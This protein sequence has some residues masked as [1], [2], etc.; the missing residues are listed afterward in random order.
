MKTESRKFTPKRD[1]PDETKA[2]KKHTGGNMAG[3]VIIGLGSTGKNICESVADKLNII[4]GSYKN[5]PN[6]G[7]KVFETAKNEKTLIAQEDY[8]HLSISQDDF[9][10]YKKNPQAGYEFDWGKWGNTSLISQLTGSGGVSAGAGGI[11]MV[12]RLALLHNYDSVSAKITKEIR[13]VDDKKSPTNVYVVGSLCGGTCSGIC[14]DFGYFIKE[15]AENAKIM[16]IFTIPLWSLKDEELK[17]NAFYAL[18]ELNHYMSKDNKWSQKVPKL[19]FSN[20]DRPYEICYLTRPETPSK[21]AENEEMIASFL[22]TAC[23]KSDQINENNV[24]AEGILASDMQFGNLVPSFSSL[25]TASMEYPISHISRIC[26]EKLLIKTYKKWLSEYKGDEFEDI[27]EQIYSKKR[28]LYT[29]PYEDWYPG[30]LSKDLETNWS[31]ANSK[32]IGELIKDAKEK[33]RDNAR[34]SIT[35]ENLKKNFIADFKNRINSSIKKNLC[36]EESGISLTRKTIEYAKNVISDFAGMLEPLT[37]RTS[38]NSEYKALNEKL[39]ATE[40]NLNKAIEDYKT[41]ENKFLFLKSK[42]KIEEAQKEIDKFLSEYIKCLIDKISWD[43][44]YDVLANDMFNNRILEFKSFLDSYLKRINELEKAVKIRL[45]ELQN[46]YDDN[47]SQRLSEDYLINGTVEDESDTL[48]KDIYYEEWPSELL[49]LVKDDLCE[50]FTSDEGSSSLDLK[51]DSGRQYQSVFEK[52]DKLK[53]NSEQKFNAE[54]SKKRKILTLLDNLGQHAKRKKLEELINRAEVSIKCDKAPNN[55]FKDAGEAPGKSYA[56]AFEPSQ[57][58]DNHLHLNR[59]FQDENGITLI[60]FSHGYSLAHMKGIM[61]SQDESDTHNLEFYLKCT[62]F[63]YWN[64]RMD[65]S[66]ANITKSQDN[67]DNI[68]LLLIVFRLLGLSRQWYTLESG[69]IK[70]YLDSYTP[71]V[72]DNRFIEIS[73]KFSEA[74][75]DIQQSDTICNEFEKTAKQKINTLFTNEGDENA[76]KVLNGHLSKFSDYDG[77]DIEMGKAQKLLLKYYRSKGLEE[78]YYSVEF[79][80]NEKIDRDKFSML[81]KDGYYRCSEGHELLPE[82]KVKSAVD[83]SDPETIQKIFR[84]MI[85]EKFICPKC[86][87]GTPPY[88]P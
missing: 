87:K 23:L 34:E 4:Y 52:L 18:S 29:L 19:S 64:T 65:V 78:S 8:I 66:W 88:W 42:K 73:Q 32:N 56:I 28:K 84:S 17:K 16:G 26:S 22:S 74:L 45:E 50:D 11:R 54:V 20:S 76:I 30:K 80:E 81:L 47:V 67:V 41:E 39:N 35:C 77:I 12:G 86:K 1:R 70:V 69:K 59:T 2:N 40:K 55:K 72:S 43:K 37:L 60:K 36:R 6:I 31:D 51:E 68:R 14:P 9:Q 75:Q 58:L 83:M 49:N 71:G 15:W 38:R 53:R 33:A 10:D 63:T 82:G 13:R 7:I 27:A 57:E 24:D 25:G 61:K 21:V 79:P 62:R 85:K 46:A 5:A 44:I 48:F 3:V